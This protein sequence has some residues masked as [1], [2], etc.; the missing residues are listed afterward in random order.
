MYSW[1]SFEKSFWCLYH[2]LWY[3]N[4]FYVSFSTVTSTMIVQRLNFKNQYFDIF[5]LLPSTKLW[6][7]ICNRKGLEVWLVCSTCDH[8]PT[9][10]VSMPVYIFNQVTSD[11]VKSLITKY[12]N[13]TVTLLCI[14]YYSNCFLV[15]H[16]TVT[17]GG[18]KERS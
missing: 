12:S 8:L 6:Q 15:Y 4:K 16:Q 9:S 13:R 14:S 7:V 3:R 17:S 2:H 18:A 1:E 10:F 5:Q 11:C